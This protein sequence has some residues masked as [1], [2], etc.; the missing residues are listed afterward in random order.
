MIDAQTV[1]DLTRS[2]DLSDVLLVVLREVEKK[3]I[4]EE[5]GDPMRDSKESVL[6]RFW[7]RLV[8]ADPEIEKAHL[9]VDPIKLD[10]LL[11]TTPSLRDRVRAF[12]GASLSTF[13]LEVRQELEDL[14]RRVQAVPQSRKK[15]LVVLFDSLEKLEGTTATPD[16]LHA[17]AAQLFVN[18]RQYLK[19][20]I[21][22]VYTVPAYLRTLSPS[23]DV[24]FMPMVKLF[25]RSGERFELGFEAMRE[26]VFRRIPKEELPGFLGLEWEVRLDRIITL[27][28]GYPRELMHTLRNLMVSE[29]AFP[30]SERA[31]SRA[32][33][34][35]RDSFEE[36]IFKEDYPWLAGVHLDKTI[37]TE[38]AQ[39]RVAAER[40]I[41][42]NAVLLYRNEGAWYE[43]HPLVREIDGVKKAIANLRAERARVLSPSAAGT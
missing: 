37:A 14:E 20:P 43:V 26:M 22:V 36:A 18:N 15:K 42:A 3:V 16:A 1:L 41:A 19:L 6:T 35:L 8:Q 7:R 28:G 33:N 39:Q 34:Q 24:P 12:V 30:V 17:S 23:L 21:H 38:D 27:S 13:S 5:G 11:K 9:G 32:L 2:L 31:V 25:N 29:D 4:Q 40:M 10:V